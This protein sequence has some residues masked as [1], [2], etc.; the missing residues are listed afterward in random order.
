L[1]VHDSGFIEK[2]LARIDQAQAQA[3]ANVEVKAGDVL[4]NITGA[5]IARTCIAPQ[6]Y[7]PAR[8]NQHVSIIRPKPELILSE[9][10]HFVLR[11]QKMKSKLLSIGDS[12]GSTR[13]ALTKVDLE[14]TFVDFPLELQN[15]REAVDELTSFGELSKN[16]KDN[17]RK[18]ELLYSD[19]GRSLLSS[20]F[21]E[22]VA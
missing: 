2:R 22:Q 21:G 7:L 18:I 14:N 15:Q 12:G 6:D 11:S 5:S 16:F 9:Y 17:L 19:L 3:L 13:Q 4:L 10:L 20:A 8:V 1:N